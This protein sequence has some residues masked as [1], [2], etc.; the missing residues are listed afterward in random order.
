M[1]NNCAERPLFHLSASGKGLF[2]ALERR[3]KGVWSRLLSSQR[4]FLHME[5]ALDKWYGKLKHEAIKRLGSTT[6]YIILYC[7]IGYI[8]LY[9]TRV[10]WMMFYHV[11]HII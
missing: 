1:A 11:I 8:N 4:G 7:Y 10:Y 9:Y 6:Y 2:L 3:F 5:K